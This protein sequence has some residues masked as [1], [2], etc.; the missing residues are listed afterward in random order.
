MTHLSKDRN[1]AVDYEAR[2]A[3]ESWLDCTMRK[4]ADDAEVGVR[5]PVETREGT[6]T[7]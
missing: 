5:T 7:C 6:S 1:Y 2:E 3:G 4:P